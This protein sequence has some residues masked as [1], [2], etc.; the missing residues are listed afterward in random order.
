MM[1][2]IEV[3]ITNKLTITMKTATKMFMVLKKEQPSSLAGE[4]EGS[5]WIFCLTWEW[6]RER[7]LIVCFLNAPFPPSEVVYTKP[8]VY[9][10]KVQTNCDS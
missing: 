2:N 7:E 4:E 6:K 8:L 1:L 9:L 5:R 3:D 10:G